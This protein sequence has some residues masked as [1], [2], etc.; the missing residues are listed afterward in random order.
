[1]NSV[2]SEGVIFSKKLVRQTLKSVEN[3]TNSGEDNIHYKLEQTN[4]LKQKYKTRD[5]NLKFSNLLDEEENFLRNLKTIENFRFEPGFRIKG[6]SVRDAKV[7][8]IT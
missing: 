6:V 1:M 3:E 7:G 4:N 8:D 2:G 5:V